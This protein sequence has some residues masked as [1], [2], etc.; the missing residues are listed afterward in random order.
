MLSEFGHSE[1]LTLGLEDEVWVW[2]PNKTSFLTLLY[3][4][5]LWGGSPSETPRLAKC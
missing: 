4:P 3:L 1:S 5:C 2:E